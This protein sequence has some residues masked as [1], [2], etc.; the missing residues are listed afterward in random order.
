M[1]FFSSI[2]K[3]KK[4]I[5]SIVLCLVVLGIVAPDIAFAAWWEY[6]IP[7]W[8]SYKIGNLLRDTVTGTAETAVNNVTNGVIFAVSGVF[9]AVSG[10]LASSAHTLLLGVTSIPIKV[11]SYV[12]GSSYTHI[13]GPDANIAVATGWP[14]A[15]DLANMFVVLGF[16]I[17]GI[18]TTLRIQEYQAKK[19]LPKLIIVALLINF[20]LLI[21]GIFI[22]GSNIT[23]GYFLNKG[24]YFGQKFMQSIETQT[25]IVGQAFGFDAIDPLS[26][27]GMVTGFVFYNIVATIIFMLFFFLFIFR[28]MALWILVI[29]SPLAFV[30][31]VFPFTKKYFEMWWNQFFA[32]CI[33]GIP[34][35]FFLFLADKVTEEATKATGVE[36]IDFATYLVPGFLLIAGF[37]FSLQTSAMGASIVTNFA[38]K[39]KGKILGGGL[40][41]LSKASGGVNN[42]VKNLTNWMAGKG[43]TTG[44]IGKG[45]GWVWDKTGGMGTGVVANYRAT[46]QKTRSA[47]GRAL[48]GAGAIPPG[49]QAGKDDKVLADAI[50]LLTAA[51]QSGNK[52]DEQRVF[53]KIHNGDTAAII[54]AV[55][56][57]KLHEAF[58]DPSTG[59]VNHSAMND[60]LVA[61]EKSGAPKNMRK[62]ALNKYEKLAG[63][64]DKNMDTALTSLGHK[65]AIDAE[66]TARGITIGTATPAQRMVAA[67]SLEASG[68]LVAGTIG[69]GQEKAIYTQLMQN[70]GSKDLETKANTDLGGLHPDDLKEFA[71][72]RNAEDI[73]SFKLLDAGHANRTTHKTTM[74]AHVSAELATPGISTNRERRLKEVRDELMKL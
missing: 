62:D 30:F 3:H 53:D 8:N 49:T 40:G 55:S 42:K 31:Y 32:W 22:D 6:L 9:M 43:G 54:A 69:R 26:L 1:K 70:W 41:A 11:G 63:F 20:S 18:A 37:L 66:L 48:E 50:K 60:S 16:V 56:E 7:V 34:A 44:T 57:G 47:F 13:T 17:I 25:N 38:N 15:R 74:L 29:L 45:A 39:N 2:L 14:I 23:M 51:L 72:S 19:L 36:N 46:A 52:K 67:R 12:F 59:A 33:I 21:C 28:Y 68:G 4:I 58:K 61:A 5:T 64:T 24:G 73:K 27:L 10:I 71:L 65:G 35:G